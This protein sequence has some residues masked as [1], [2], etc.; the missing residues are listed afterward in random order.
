MRK[1][2]QPFSLERQLFAEPSLWFDGSGRK[3]DKGG[4]C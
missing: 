3:F 2:A 4:R 1:R